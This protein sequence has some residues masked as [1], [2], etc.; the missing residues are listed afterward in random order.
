LLRDLSDSITGPMQTQCISDQLE[1][2]VRRYSAVRDIPTAWKYTDGVSDDRRAT[3]AGP[4]SF[5]EVIRLVFDDARVIRARAQSGS[6]RGLT[7]CVQPIFTLELPNTGDALFNGPWGY[8]AQYWVSPGQGLAANCMLL[9]ALTPKLLGA[10]NTREEQSL[11][12][13]DVCASLH[14]ASAKIWIQEV[15]SLLINP[16]ADLDVERWALEARNGVEL[17][18]WGLSAPQVTK[19]EVKGALMDPYGNEVVPVRKVR[20]H[21]D[22]HHYGFS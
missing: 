4:G 13:L 14:A 1:F 18:R 8:R 11:A 7:D 5:D 16:T 10:M 9:A 17:A 15:P 6:D 3:L 2:A 21:Y 22:I 19:F 12:K 20:R